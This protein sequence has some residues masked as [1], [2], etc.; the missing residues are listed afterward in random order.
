MADNKLAKMKAFVDHFPHHPVYMG[1]DVHKISYHVA[2]LRADGK[3][4]TLVMPA[5]P[6]AVLK[7]I[8]D[9]GAPLGALA[10]ESGPTGFVLARTLEAAGHR[11]IVAASCRIPRQPTPGA[12]T[13]S[14]DCRKLASYAAKGLLKPIAVP[15][16]TQEAER[17][18]I[19]RRD[20]ISKDIRV[21]KQRIKSLLLQFNLPEPAGL[22]NWSKRSL[23]ALE[24]LALPFE[25]RITLDSLIDALRSLCANRD[26]IMQYIEKVKEKDTHKEVC[27]NLQATPGVGPVVAAA[28]RLELF[29]PE[30]FGSAGEVASYLGLAPMVRQSG[31]RSGSS[32]LRPVG[33]RMLR[34]LL[35]EAAWQFKGK[36]PRA[37]A[38]Y[39][40]LLNRHGLP[41]KAIV[42]V[43]RKLAVLLWRLCVENRPYEVRPVGAV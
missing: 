30:R 40:K 14:L 11:V 36:D 21:C 25:A 15:S 16:E 9:L 18:L 33:Q 29:D 7:L 4:E 10:Y 12:K 17:T 6:T 34:A 5:D 37:R 24:Q 22:Q 13:D 35:V 2:V 32:R 28:F 8:S 23:A 39:N 31:E 43:A 1:L 26:S 20:Q 41:Q 38:L 27:A 19:R 3:V 42:A